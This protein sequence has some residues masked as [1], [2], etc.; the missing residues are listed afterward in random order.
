MLVIFVHGWST[1]GTSTYGDLPKW[2]AQQADAQ[3]LDL[4]VGH[5][6]LGRYVSF[7]DTVTLD[8]V[9]RAFDQAL[10]DTLPNGGKGQRFACITHS[11]GGPV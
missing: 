9:A 8:D 3:G 4:Q 2:L 11:T 6:Y 1:T 10:A 5:I 7:V